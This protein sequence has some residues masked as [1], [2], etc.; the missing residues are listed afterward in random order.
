MSP[1]RTRELVVG[2]PGFEPGTSCAQARRVISW[3]SFPCNI[4]FENKRLPEKFGRGKKYENVPPH[5]QGPPNFPHSK[6]IG[7]KGARR[8]PLNA[9]TVVAQS[10][11]WPV[12]RAG[13]VVC[14]VMVRAVP[15]RTAV[16]EAYLAPLLQ[17]VLRIS[18][19]PAVLP[20]PFAF[21]ASSVPSGAFGM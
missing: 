15:S 19:A 2:A 5:A 18:S 11:V 1:G 10:T 8:K 4:V 13:P 6:R 20:S 7:K 9:P 12:I 16:L 3:K 14:L 21:P 17:R